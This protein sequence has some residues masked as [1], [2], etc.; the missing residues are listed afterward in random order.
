MT[1][2]ICLVPWV[3]TARQPTLPRRF[4]HPCSSALSLLPSC[5][6]KFQDLKVPAE[7][8]SILG[9]DLLL[10]SI[11]TLDHDCQRQYSPILS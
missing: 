8:E 2:V 3:P 7:D 5:A 11:E 1:E 10:A 6:G 4:A 9:S